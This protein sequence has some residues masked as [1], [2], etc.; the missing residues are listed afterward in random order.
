MV[1]YLR[2]VYLSVRTSAT[3]AHESS[4]HR[5]H[6]SRIY[7]CTGCQLKDGHIFSAE[8]YLRDL[9][10]DVDGVFDGEWKTT[11]RADAFTSGSFS[12]DCCCIVENLQEVQA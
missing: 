6:L 1:G 11:K 8:K 10:F 4:T 12:V 3:L 5:L 9:P 7:R 2:S